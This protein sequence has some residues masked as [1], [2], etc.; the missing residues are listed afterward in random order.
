MKYFVDEKIIC[1]EHKSKFDQMTKPKEK[2]VIKT[3][4]VKTVKPFLPP[5]TAAPKDYTQ[6]EPG[7][8]DE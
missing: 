5:I 1:A 4:P 6:R 7:S 3:E 8:D 2:Y